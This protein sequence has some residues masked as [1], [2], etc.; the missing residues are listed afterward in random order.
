MRHLNPIII[1][2]INYCRR[3]AIIIILL[4]IWMGVVGGGGGGVFYI[5]MTMQ[6][7]NIQFEDLRFELR[8]VQS[9]EFSLSELD[10]LP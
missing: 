3:I 9:G 4:V 2:L 8:W 10:P 7:D 5:T 6:S 1:L